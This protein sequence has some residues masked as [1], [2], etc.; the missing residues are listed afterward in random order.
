M[1]QLL[2][3][4]GLAAATASLFAYVAYATFETTIEGLKLV[5]MMAN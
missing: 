2:T 5:A 4:T 3:A 1:T